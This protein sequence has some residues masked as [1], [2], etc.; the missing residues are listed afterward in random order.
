MEFIYYYIKKK[1]I[2][3]IKPNR[4]VCCIEEG[5]KGQYQN[6][7]ALS[8]KDGEKRIVCL[9]NCAFSVALIAKIFKNE[10]SSTETVYLVTKD[11]EKGNMFLHLL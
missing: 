3:G 6:L 5:K 4:S 7:S 9:K 8:L 1:F 2:I 11:L 10:D